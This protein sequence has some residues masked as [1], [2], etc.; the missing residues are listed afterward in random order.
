[1]GCF[2][3]GRLA[4]FIMGNR[5]ISGDDVMDEGKSRNDRAKSEVDKKKFYFCCWLIVTI[6]VIVLYILFPPFLRATGSS[7]YTR[8]QSN[9]KQIGTALELYSQD[10]EGLYPPKMEMLMPKYIDKIPRCPGK[11]MQGKEWSIGR[12]LPGRGRYE[13]TYR[14]GNGYESYTFYCRGLRHSAVGIPFNH[15]QYS[16]EEGVIMRE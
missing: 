12:I 4:G 16:S 15:P 3:G 9:M 5:L 8:C 10:N 14:A 7:D 2:Y 11:D 1:M 6:L 13:Q